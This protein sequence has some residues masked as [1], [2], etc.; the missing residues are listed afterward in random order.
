MCKRLSRSCTS[1]AISGTQLSGS[2][3]ILAASGRVALARGL[4]M[5]LVGRG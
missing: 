2:R 4:L 3:K 5:C 1:S